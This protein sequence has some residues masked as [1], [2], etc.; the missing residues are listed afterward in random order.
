M[1]KVIKN[2][3]II[4]TFVVI[5]NLS[6][7]GNCEASLSSKA[8]L[9][10]EKL[11]FVIVRTIEGDRTYINIYTDTGILVMKVEEL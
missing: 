2:L 7:T 10:S 3:V 9:S 11:E 5:A 6:F 8:S 1:K 4:F